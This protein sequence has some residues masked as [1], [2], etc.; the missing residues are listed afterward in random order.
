MRL[1]TLAML[2]ATQV[3]AATPE[4]EF[5]ESKIRP[6]L[7]GRCYGCHAESATAGLRVDS[8][9][10]LLRGGKSGPAIKPGDP[11]G[12]ILL[13][14]I[15][16]VKGRMAMPPAGDRV[17][18][19]ERQSLRQWIEMGAPWPLSPGEFFAARVRPLLETKCLG[20][21]ADDPQGGLRM[22][23]R[24]AFLRGGTSG[25]AIIPGD[26][27]ASLLVLAVHYRH[28][29]K[30][31]LTGPLSL[32]ETETLA[33]WVK[34]G[35]AWKSDPA[36]ASEPYVIS[37]E[38]KSHWAFQ[39][40]ADVAVPSVPAA[41]PSDNAIDR[42]LL[43]KLGLAG[44]EASDPASKRALIRRVT[45][46]LTGL[47]PSP[48]EIEAFLADDSGD[49]WT[50]LVEKLLDSP[51]YGERW[52][53]HWLDLVR[54]AD[55]AGDSGDFPV[56]EAYKYRN[57]VIDSFQRDRPYDE[58]VREQ[59]AG[60]LLESDTEGERWDRV[61]ATGYLA[62]SRRI[63]VNPHNLRHIM[64]EDAIDN[65]GKTFLG[66]SVQCARC[67]DHKFD[68]IPTA[69]YYSLYGILDSSV[70]PHP[71]AEHRP[72]R[73]DFVYRVGE[74][75]AKKVRAS[76]AAELTDWNEREREKFREYQSFQNMLVTTPGRN[77]E[78]VWGELQVLRAE[79]AVF[80]RTEPSLETAYA[81]REGSPRDVPIH[82]AGDPKAPGPMVR[83]GFLQIL[84]GAKLPPGYSGSGRLMLAEW[85]ADPQNPL[86][87]RVMVNRIWHH[88]FGAGL[89]RTTSDFGVRGAQ[90]THPELLDYLAKYFIDSGWS[91]KAVHRLI[92]S[93]SAY[94]RSSS[95][96]DASFETDPRN[97]L[98]WRFNRRRL[99]AEQIR[100]SVLAFSGDLDDTRGNRHPFPHRQ[101]YFYR[102]HEP[103]S[104]FFPTNRRS[105]YI[106]QPR[107][108]KHPYLDLFDGPDGNLPM[109]ER[110]STTTT[111]QAL[112]LM[113][114]EFVHEQSRAIAERL[115]EAGD[116]PGAFLARTTQAIYGRPPRP[117]EA[118]RAAAYF[119]QA[120]GS[121]ER[122]RAG[123]VRAML[124]SNEFLFVD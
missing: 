115:T 108:Q 76:Y 16:G 84:G 88:H 6:V 61:I 99:D 79:R 24:E 71:G 56:P 103:F 73:T 81:I 55:T 50:N 59:I 31:P 94:R 18:A 100:D 120:E 85:I 64:L 72:H 101:T 49:A 63:G 38:H 67:H 93:S 9:E 32:A 111:L 90:P 78:V 117:E 45:Y 48:A 37:A 15:Q 4:E 105:V 110:K 113:N 104:E 112:Y 53:R 19:H 47:P 123:L 29:L 41:G 7:A 116:G 66:L 36:P 3:L 1:A 21:H 22:D 44:L 69:D 121:D 35:A 17:A 14:A 10:G 70:F 68:P 20:C 92:L 77:R 39:P 119:Q 95:D 42:F 26:P 114:S 51:R 8:R 87:A 107:I 27:D 28:D 97:L 52:G 11:D 58:F 54:Y 91:V 62:I 118:G 12:S 102:Q 89:V 2:A 57:Y 43:A 86:T 96:N 109:S 82:R 46:D 34:D 106:M 60:D 74:E 65:L 98:L 80:A 122:K 23:S 25:P 33:R 30:M 83:R 13:H 75:A 124:A 40:L 5:F